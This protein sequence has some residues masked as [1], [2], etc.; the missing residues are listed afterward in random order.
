M[1]GSHGPCGDQRISRKLSSGS[2][3]GLLD[4]R[5]ARHE[6]ATMKGTALFAEMAPHPLNVPISASYSIT[7]GRIYINKLDQYWSS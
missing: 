2:E 1:A 5:F 6:F 7:L 4:S 3:H